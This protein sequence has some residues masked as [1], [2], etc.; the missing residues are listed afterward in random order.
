MIEKWYIKTLWDMSQL[1]RLEHIVQ[2]ANCA[3]HW[4]LGQKAFR[5]G[6]PQIFVVSKIWI[7]LRC[8]YGPPSQHTTHQKY[9]TTFDTIGLISP[10]WYLRKCHALP[11]LWLL[12]IF[13]RCRISTDTDQTKLQR[14]SSGSG[15]HRTKDH[16]YWPEVELNFPRCIVALQ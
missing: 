6:L 7:S 2:T 8:G 4:W 1:V 10:C 13:D 9:C 14:S 16:T 11:L 3:L 12:T 5:K 15:L